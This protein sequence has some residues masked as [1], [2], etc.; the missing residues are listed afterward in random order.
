MYTYNKQNSYEALHNQ[1]D[2]SC[3]YQ[4]VFYIFTFL[5]Y[6]GSA[7]RSKADVGAARVRHKRNQN[8]NI[9]SV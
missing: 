5:S 1:I 7:N 6:D 3:A 9:N 8:I 4:H 2:C